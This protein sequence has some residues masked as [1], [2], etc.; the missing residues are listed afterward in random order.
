VFSQL[1]KLAIEHSYD[2]GLLVFLWQA[3]FLD[4]TENSK[5]QFLEKD[6]SGPVEALVKNTSEFV[7]QIHNPILFPSFPTYH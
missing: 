6:V 7:L 4:P 3:L 2:K 5:E 1:N